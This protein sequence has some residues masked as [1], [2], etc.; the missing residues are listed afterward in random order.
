MARLPVPG[1][2]DGT[3]GD[4][5]N[6]FLEVAHNNDGTLKAISASGVSDFNETVRDT[7]GSTLAAGAGTSL[8]I[9]D[10]ADSITVSNVRTPVSKTSDHTLELSDAFKTVV[11]NAV[12]S[13]FPVLTI[14]PNSDVAFPIGTIICVRQGAAARYVS[15]SPGSGVTINA[16]SGRSVGAL[17]TVALH[18]EA[19]D[20]WTISSP[21]SASDPGVLH[22]LA[23]LPPGYMHL[24]TVSTLSLNGAVWVPFELVRPMAMPSF[25]IRVTT[26]SP[27]Q[28]FNLTIYEADTSW[29]ATSFIGNTI[30]QAAV[31]G[32]NTITPGARTLPPGRYMVKLRYSDISPIEIRAL[33]CAPPFVDPSIGATAGVQHLTGSS[34]GNDW[35]SATLAT[36]GF[37]LPFCFSQRAM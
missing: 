25:L 1:S 13:V 16:P 37:Q 5:L 15:I 14:P 19:S 10:A 32:L 6:E 21:T 24:G 31:N 27:E 22:E 8:A 4:V 20:T 33:N 2:D 7:V 28:Q 30:N 12:G 26:A 18:K 34:G 29:N 23:A 17:Q 36:G 35:S 3:W 9:D 11:F